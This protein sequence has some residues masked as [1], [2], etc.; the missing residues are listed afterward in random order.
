MAVSDDGLAALTGGSGGHHRAPCHLEHLNLRYTNITDAA[1]VS[2]AAACPELTHLDLKGCRGVTS[3]GLAAVREGC[4]DNLKVSLLPDDSR[5]VM[6]AL[7]LGNLFFVG[8]ILYGLV[9][10]L[11]F[12]ILYADS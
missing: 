3:A 8:I 7:V 1:L 6:T 2:L 5:S 12:L 4:R 9:T 11:H 10:L